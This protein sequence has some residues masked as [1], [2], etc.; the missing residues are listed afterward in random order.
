MACYRVLL[1]KWGN[2]VSLT[3]ELVPGGPH[4]IYDFCSVECREKGWTISGSV[5]DWVRRAYE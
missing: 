5:E 2:R 4:N 1:D 3:H